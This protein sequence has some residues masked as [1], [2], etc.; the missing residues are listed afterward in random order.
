MQSKALLKL[1]GLPNVAAVGVQACQPLLRQL[2]AYGMGSHVSDNDPDVSTG[3]NWAQTLRQGPSYTPTSSDH[4]PTPS[5]LL[6]PPP[7]SSI[8]PKSA[9][10]KVRRV[11]PLA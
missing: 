4:M 1:G 5:P 10:S 11:E 3:R 6:P 2:R 7:R 8:G 9:T